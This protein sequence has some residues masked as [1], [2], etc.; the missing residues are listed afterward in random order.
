MRDIDHYL[1]EL[2]AEIEQLRSCMTTPRAEDLAEIERLRVDMQTAN[3]AWDELAIK[4]A[5]LQAVVDA[6]LQEIKDGSLTNAE[7]ELLKARAALEGEGE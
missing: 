6:A 7:R 1:A 5:K 3:D 4:N 2:E